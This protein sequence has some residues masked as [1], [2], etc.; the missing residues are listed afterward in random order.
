MY[1]SL[2]RYVSAGEC[3]LLSHWF[4]KA[5]FWFYNRIGAIISVF[6]EDL[7]YEQN[8]QRH[9]ELL[10]FI[11]SNEQ[12]L[13]FV[14]I[15]GYCLGEVQGVKVPASEYILFVFPSQDRAIPEDFNSLDKEI[16]EKFGENS[17]RFFEGQK[18]ELTDK[19]YVDVIM[20][21]FKCVT[22]IDSEIPVHIRE[23]LRRLYLYSG[24]C[25]AME[26]NNNNRICWRR[27]WDIL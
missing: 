17:Y 15:E 20:G 9:R 7:S 23:M 8:L 21:S 4:G 5:S 19:N 6:K 27:G 13:L 2:S 24:R 3:R 14:E 18:H 10:E 1:G 26:G 11:K 12:K 25:R 22:K 16:I